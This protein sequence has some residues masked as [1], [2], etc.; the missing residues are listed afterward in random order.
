MGETQPTRIHTQKPSNKR[1]FTS[2]EISFI[3]SDKAIENV[4]AAVEGA[5]ESACS[6]KGAD[7]T[8]STTVDG[9]TLKANNAIQEI[10]DLPMLST[11][12]EDNGSSLKRGVMVNQDS[13]LYTLIS[14][15]TGK[16]FRC[17]ICSYES[18]AT[19]DIRTHVRRHTGEKP[20]QCTFEGC[21]YRSSSSSDMSVH[22]KRH[23]KEKPHHCP[24][25]GC[26]HRTTTSCHMTSHIR[27]HNKPTYE[28]K[29]CFFSTKSTKAAELHQKTHPVSI[30]TKGKHVPSYF[31]HAC[32]H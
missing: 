30:V 4:I 31:L 18:A 27:S 32:M 24:F 3:S 29:L 23:R 25:P 2:T 1:A 6:D 7:D 19:G 12:A 8:I 16:R 14:E 26:N 10:A 28:C 17:N 11:N 5:H 13:N 22:L 21:A 15:S 20:F 9:K